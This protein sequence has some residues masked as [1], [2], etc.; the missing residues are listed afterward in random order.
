MNR[1]HEIAPDEHARGPQDAALTLIEYGDFQCPYCA[2]A[3]AALGG[4]PRAPKLTIATPA[5]A[6]R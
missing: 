1:V 6:H 3:H 2:R 5:A 4:P